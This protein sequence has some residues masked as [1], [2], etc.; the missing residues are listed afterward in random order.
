MHAHGG[1]LAR[2]WP[3]AYSRDDEVNKNLNEAANP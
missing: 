2:E 1:V 3:A